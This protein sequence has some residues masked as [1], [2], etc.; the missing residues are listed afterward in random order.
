MAKELDASRGTEALVRELLSDALQAQRAG[1]QPD[2]G[3]R[4]QTRAVCACA[5]EDGVPIERVLVTLKEEWRATPAARQLKRFEATTLL[6]RIVTLC[7]TE[8]YADPTAH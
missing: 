8:F 6:E 5:H 7:I 2:D 3:L 4:Q 1:R